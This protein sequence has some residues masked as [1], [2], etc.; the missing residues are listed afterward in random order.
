MTEP[1][2]TPT[3]DEPGDED[4]EDNR[5]ATSKALRI[6]F[7]LRAS[8]YATMFLREVTRTSSAFSTQQLLSS[9]ANKS[10]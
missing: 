6:K 4:G 3:T 8:S 7:S 1:D 2:P 5:G 10:R 9:A